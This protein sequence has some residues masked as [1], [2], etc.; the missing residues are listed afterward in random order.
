MLKKTYNLTRKYSVYVGL[1]FGLIW[2]AALSNYGYGFWF[3]SILVEHKVENHLLDRSY[4]GGDVLTIFLS[5][6]WGSIR[7]G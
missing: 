6:M 1:S 7:L 3:G 5:V 4:N 2:F